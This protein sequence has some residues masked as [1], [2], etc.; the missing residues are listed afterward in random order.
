MHNG[1]YVTVTECATRRRYVGKFHLSCSECELLSSHARPV[2]PPPVTS[3]NVIKTCI[4]IASRFLSLH[5]R[6][7]GFV[8]LFFNRKQTSTV[9]ASVG[10]C[11]KDRWP[12]PLVRSQFQKEL[13]V[14]VVRSSAMGSLCLT[15]SMQVSSHVVCSQFH[16][17]FSVDVGCYHFLYDPVPE[18]PLSILQLKETS[19]VNVS[20]IAFTTRGFSALFPTTHVAV[21]ACTPRGCTTRGSHACLLCNPKNT[22]SAS[23]LLSTGC[24]GTAC[25][26][27]ELCLTVLQ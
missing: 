13:A 27:C 8:C 20:V 21:I 26:I 11:M 2:A 7:V 22:C 17:E 15:K 14:D 23:R 18:P 4:C 9:N 10:H 24:C 12:R 16:K 19:M 1:P 25:L 3:A 5:V 6:P